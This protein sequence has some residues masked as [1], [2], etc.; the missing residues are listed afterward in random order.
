MWG[1]VLNAQTHSR[2]GSVKPMSDSSATRH[3]ISSPTHGRSHT[4]VGLITWLSRTTF[5]RSGDAS[6][7][8]LTPCWRFVRIHCRRTHGCTSEEGSAHHEVGCFAPLALRLP[9]LVASPRSVATEALSVR[10]R[11]IGLSRGTPET[12][13][14]QRR[15]WLDGRD[16]RGVDSCQRAM[17]CQFGAATAV[18][19]GRKPS[20]QTNGV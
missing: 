6:T 18:H 14:R 2:H 15:R 8:L 20:H 13:A 3:E 16:A 10:A 19:C 1:C 11:D 17:G 5:S 4:T 7:P 9:L 12:H